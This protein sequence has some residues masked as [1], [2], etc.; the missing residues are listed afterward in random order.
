M[1]ILFFL[2]ILCPSVVSAMS[3]VEYNRLQDRIDY[4]YSDFAKNQRKIKWESTTVIAPKMSPE[5]KEY[6]KE[7][8]ENKIEEKE[9]LLNKEPTELV[10]EA[11]NGG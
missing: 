1:K 2:L 8:R 6:L 7:K 4:K 3:E 9:K 5:L 10:K 11:D